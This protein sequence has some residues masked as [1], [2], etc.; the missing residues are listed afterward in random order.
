MLENKN[1]NHI[2]VLLEDIKIFIQDQAS[3]QVDPIRLYDGTFGG[4]GYTRFFL[5]IGQVVAT[6]ADIHAI[7]QG[8]I[9]FEK[10]IESKRLTLVNTRFDQGLLDY[11]DGYFDYIVVDLG[12]SSNQ[13]TDSERGFSYQNSEEELDMRYNEQ[14]GDACWELLYCAKDVDKLRRVIYN[15]SGEALSKRIA[16]NIMEMVKSKITTGKKPILVG[17]VVDSVLG[18]IPQRDK[19]HSNAILSRVWQALRIWTNNEFEVLTAFLDNSLPKLKVNGY[20]MVVSFHSLEDK[21]VTKHMRTVAKPQQ[22]D[23]YG[24]T[25]VGY[26]LITKKATTPSAQ[27]IANNVRSRSAMLRILQ[28]LV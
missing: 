28:K 10:A 23:D 26:K 20:L 8:E 17:D 5:E 14:R 27:E 2:P 12:F 19:K 11:E 18:S 3:S 22:I 6:D 13:L 25:T 4:G 1:N 15:Y 9:N 24:N 21:I 16:E 7:N